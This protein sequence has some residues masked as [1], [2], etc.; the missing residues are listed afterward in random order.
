M[1][2]VINIDS[3]NRTDDIQWQSFQISDNI[4]NQANSCTFES[5]KHKPELGQEVEV[6]FNSEKIFGG[7]VVKIETQRDKLLLT[8][9][10]TCKDYSQYLNRQLVSETFINQTADEIIEYIRDEYAPDFTIDNVNAPINITQITFNRITVAQA[11]ETL[12]N[13][14]N[15]Y[16]YVDYDKDIHFFAKQ[17]ELAPFNL[18]D[19]AGNHNWD[20]LR[21]TEDF[22]Q[23]RNQI[24]VIGGEYEG[25]ERVESYVADGTQQQFPLAY[26]YKTITRVRIVGGPD[27]TV[28]IDG[29]DEETNF[30][31]MW[32]YSQ[33]YIKFKIS[34][35]PDADDVVEVTGNPLFPVI[36]KVPDVSSIAEFGLYEFKIVDK[37]I[38]S[39]E[40]AVARGVAELEAYANSLEEGSFDTY[41]SGLRTG[42]TINI[43]VGDTDEDFVIQSVV[44]RMRGNELPVYNVKIATTRTLGIIQFLQ[45]YLLKDEDVKQG[46]TLLELLEFSDDSEITDTLDSITT[47]EPPYLYAD[48]TDPADEGKW[49]LATWA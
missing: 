5:V 6:L 11:L 27:L 4:N 2:F 31:V 15:Y 7:V 9:K 24:Y 38:S 23:I 39:R 29:E 36:V 25:D 14:L 12:A 37:N 28:G 19:S 3:V 43:N 20:S 16:W 30:D 46:E 26:K 1:S 45:R 32:S 22:S 44:M 48:A 47:R 8:Y 21:I 35:F 41:E 40:D 49:N 17:D 33:K 34:N 18:S 13:T 42:Q 10:I